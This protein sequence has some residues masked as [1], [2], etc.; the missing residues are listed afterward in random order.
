MNAGGRGRFLCAEAGWGKLESSVKE[1]QATM[2]IAFMK[3]TPI[4][5][6]IVSSMKPGGKLKVISY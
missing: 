5:F 2:A 4:I 6:S 1:Q 3:S